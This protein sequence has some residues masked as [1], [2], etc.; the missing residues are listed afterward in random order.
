MADQVTFRIDGSQVRAWCYVDDF[1]DGLAAAV[2]TREL[3]GE[4]INLGN[5]DAAA[6]VMELANIVLR[7]AESDSQIVTEPHFGLDIRKRTPNIDKARRL[8]SFKP[9]VGLEEGLARTVGWYKKNV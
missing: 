3:S 8:L 4:V 2:E 5:P 9:V 6:S 1:I 7:A